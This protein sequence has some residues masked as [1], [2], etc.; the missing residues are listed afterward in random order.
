MIQRIKQYIK[1]NNLICRGEKLVLGVSGGADSMALLHIMMLLA[2]EWDLKLYV[3]HINHGIREEAWKDADYVEQFCQTYELPVFF[4]SENIPLLAQKEGKSEEEMGRV[5]RYRCFREIVK[6]EAGDKIV[7]AHHENDQAE[8]VLFHLIRGTNLKGL[9]GISP[10]FVGE[11]GIPI[12]R[13]LLCVNRNEIEQYLCSHDISWQEDVTN[14]DNLYARNALRNIVVPALNDINSQAISH[15]ARLAQDIRAYEA[16]F[17]SQVQS[18]L[19]TN[20]KYQNQNVVINREKLLE[21]PSVFVQGVLYHLIS[22]VCGRKKDLS[23]EHVEALYHLLLGQSGRTIDLPYGVTAFVMYENLILCPSFVQ[24]RN[25]ED[26]IYLDHILWEENRDYAVKVAGFGEVLI[27][28]RRY[29]EHDG[30]S[31]DFV[32]AQGGNVK[33]NY[34]KYFNCDKIIAALCLRTPQQGDYL[35]MN[36]Q[37]NHKKLSKYFKDAKIPLDVRRRIP[38][39]ALEHEILYVAGY[40]RCEAYKVNETTNKILIVTYKGEEDGSY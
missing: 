5:Y 28:C 7:V 32:P 26:I 24:E 40:R 31:L 9:S 17:E 10:L 35:C 21:N 34:T 14:Q 20:V 18:Y 30:T 15:I 27:S 37:G 16:F 29:G 8:T 3:V 2:K 33:N 12:V 36:E 23:N 4:F 22:D 39:L 38:I 6:K 19:Q 13:P 25:E 11:D 1:E